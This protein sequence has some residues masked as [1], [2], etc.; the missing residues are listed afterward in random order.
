MKGRE[1]KTRVTP[2]TSIRKTV[3]VY[4]LINQLENY[5]VYQEIEKISI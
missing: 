2:S 4:V 1:G 5:L 3:I